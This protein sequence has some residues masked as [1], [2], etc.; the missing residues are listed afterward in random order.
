MSLVR[1][2]SL[3]A[4]VWFSISAGASANESYSANSAPGFRWGLG[5]IA[6]PTFE[7]CD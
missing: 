1:A 5:R 2:M 3:I 7:G 6:D 4:T